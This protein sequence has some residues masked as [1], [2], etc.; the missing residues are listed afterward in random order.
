MS[1]HFATKSNSARIVTM[2][3]FHAAFW[4][5]ALAIYIALRQIRGRSV[6]MY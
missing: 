1:D 2:H 5:A 6:A 3:N 4:M